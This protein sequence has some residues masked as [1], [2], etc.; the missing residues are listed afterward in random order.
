M[1]WTTVETPNAK[2]VLI[3]S[4]HY[5]MTHR[6]PKEFD[7]LVLERGD[8]EPSKVTG[9]VTYWDLVKQAAERRKKVWIVDAAQSEKSRK[10]THAKQIASAV[11]SGVG[12]GL[13]VLT[14]FL[15]SKKK[16]SR[17]AFLAGTT[18]SLGLLSP[19][20]CNQAMLETLKLVHDKEI[21]R[22][23]LW[24][25]SAA[26]SELFISSPGRIK[27]R[28]LVS[29]EKMEGF[30]A[31]RLRKELGRKP[32]IAVAWGSHHYGIVKLLQHPNKRQQLLKKYNLNKW[33]KK[34]Y[35]KSFKIHLGKYGN[36]LKVE[37]FKETL[38]PKPKRK[39]TKKE[40]KISRR[41]FFRR[42][43]RRV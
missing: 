5:V 27:L 32:V 38:K 3:F 15:R 26:L 10:V 30:L 16:I 11:S 28:N 20:I 43:I 14:A 40:P 24:H 8:I 1:A 19:F 6:S 9:A 39:A 25:L 34:D 33:L 36:V 18:I 37:E 17:R 4:P 23:G 2:Y 31:P 13:V 41:E 35:P 42:A 22:R 21:E 7:A 29:A 12:G